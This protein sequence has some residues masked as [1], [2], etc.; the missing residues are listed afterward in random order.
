MDC[1]RCTEEGL[2][3]SPDKCLVAQ[4]MIFGWAVRGSIKGTESH[5]VCLTATSADKRADE[6]MLSTTRQRRNKP[7]SISTT[8]TYMMQMGDI[9]YNSQRRLPHLLWE[10]LVPLLR[11]AYFKT[12]DL[13]MLGRLCSVCVRER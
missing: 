9:A 7:L 12:N 13:G 10:L 2:A 1:N 3:Y 5:H 6:E 4:N 8:P 11:N